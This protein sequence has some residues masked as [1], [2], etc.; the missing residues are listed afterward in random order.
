VLILLILV[1][2]SSE[3]VLR[4]FRGVSLAPRI[5]RKIPDIRRR[6]PTEIKAIEVVLFLPP[7]RLLVESKTFFEPLYTAWSKAIGF[8]LFRHRKI[9]S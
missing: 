6:K 4:I 8:R 7:M 5:I 1:E 3:T 9:Q 2:S